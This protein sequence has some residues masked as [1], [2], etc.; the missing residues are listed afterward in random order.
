[1]SESKNKL[2]HTFQ[3]NATIR[4]YFIIILAILYYS[5]KVYQYDKK[6]EIIKNKK[7][8]DLYNKNNNLDFFNSLNST[9]KELLYLYISYIIDRKKT[10]GAKFN[11]IISGFKNSCTTGFISSSLTGVPIHYSII[12]GLTMGSVNALYKSITNYYNYKNIGID[13]IIFK[14]NFKL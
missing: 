10:E 9:D 1:M 3:T 4:L 2:I 11:K 7:I 14:N 12:S 8:I 13:D 5:Y 6:M